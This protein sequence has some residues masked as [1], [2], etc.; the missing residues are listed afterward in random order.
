MP[1][2]IAF[3]CEVSERG[4]SDFVKALSRYQKETQRDMRS[5][6]RSATIDLVKS[7]RARTRKAPKVVPRED[8]RWGESDPKYL[9][10][11]RRQFRRVVVSR[12]HNGEKYQR[13]HWQEVMRRF[14]R[15]M[16]MR[17]GNYQGIVT[18]SEATPAMLREARHRFGG[19]RQWG[20]AKKSWGW[21]MKSL[22]GKS[23]Q[24]ENPKALITSRMVD[25]GIREFREVLPD[26]TVDRMAPVRCDIDIVNRL[27]YIRK[28]MTPLA[29]EISVE[30]ATNLINH[31][32]N[33]GLKSRRFGT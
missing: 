11:D 2:A 31:K 24:D 21:F 10:Y 19:I 16:G 18:A 27:E 32:I 3:E 29:L 33:Q 12:W 13:V 1:A 8:V 25:G 20:L 28:A 14:R 30:K 6:L 7:L 22:F 4:I 17:N 15:R 26:G 23:M 5:A 9:T